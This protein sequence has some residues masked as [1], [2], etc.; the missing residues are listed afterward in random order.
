MVP[1]SSMAIRSS[2]PGIRTGGNSAGLPLAG[3]DDPGADPDPDDPSGYPDGGFSSFGGGKRMST[4]I[5]MR[6]GLVDVNPAPKP[7]DT[8]PGA[9]DHAL[10]Y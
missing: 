6:Q 2:A 8:R 5:V 3:E 10:W 1:A 4:T 9:A 7:L